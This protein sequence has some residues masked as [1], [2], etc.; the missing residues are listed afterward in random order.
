M[1]QWGEAELIEER[2]QE[3]AR[4]DGNRVA[5]RCKGRAVTFAGL[6][7][8]LRAL[9]ERVGSSKGIRAVAILPDGVAPYLLHLHFFVGGGT[10]VLQSPAVTPDGLSAI[11]SRLRPGMVVT[12]PALLP[13][14]AELD[15]GCPVLLACEDPKTT[16][17]VIWE[18]KEAGPEIARGSETDVRVVLFTSGSTGSPK[19]V[20]LGR[21]ALEGA[22][23]INVSIL[24]LGRE[25]RSLAT[26]PLYD[27]YGLIQIYSH[28]L[29][30]GEL[31][32]GETPIFPASVLHQV[33]R[34]G[35]TDL[36]GVP[37][38]LRQI[39]GTAA[40]TGD[41]SL[42]GLQVVTSSSE[43]LSTD[44]LR[45]IFEQCPDATV[46]DIYGLNE[47]G[48]A[49][50]LAIRR[51]QEENRSIGRPSPGVTI[52]AGLSREEPGEIL[53]QGP[54]LMLGYLADVTPEG[55]LVYERCDLARTGDLGF[56]DDDGNLQLTGRRDD[57]LNVHGQKIHPLEI[58]SIV[59]ESGG[60]SD[61]RA[62]VEAAAEPE[63]ILEV[64]TGDSDFDFSALWRL[65][66]EQLPFH[67]VPRRIIPVEAIARTELGSKMVRT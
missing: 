30:G 10:L 33:K 58:E 7:E 34:L 43:M 15:F 56:M 66:R 3:L 4:D 31:V 28:L 44:I 25:R 20:C 13:K 35:V 45:L 41:P 65:L 24:S 40:K 14:Y 51:G 17:D 61:A 11:L 53:I 50:S 39:F 12:S 60:V 26:V 21:E 55:R 64:V 42:G 22:A 9:T 67:F 63:L 46:F 47:A 16:E 49:S 19:G 2:L 29:A 6:A 5:L 59:L 32:I 38:G 18:W 54:N 57:L 37:F 36:V 62:R 23:S 48:R 8:A 52:T 27:Y 1:A